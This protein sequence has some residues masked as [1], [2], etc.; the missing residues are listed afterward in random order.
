[1][2]QLVA[3]EPFAGLLKKIGCE[4]E[5]RTVSEKNGTVGGTIKNV[6]IHAMLSVRA[7]AKAAVFFLKVFPMLPSRPVD[8]LTKRPEVEKVRYPTRLGQAEGEVYRPST[9]DPHPGIVVCL[10]V[11]PFGVDHPQVPI[12]GKA[13]ARAGFAALLYWSPAMR[14]FRLDA[15]DV[16]NIALAYD[17]FIQQPYVDAAR[18]GLLGTCVGG[19]FALMT[20]ARPLVRDRVAFVGAYAPY[21]SMW[22]FARDIASATRS[23]AEGCEPWQVDPLTRKVFVHSLAAWLEPGES[24]RFLDAFVSE[25]GHLDD[26]GLSAEG[27]AVHALLTA[28]DAD[29]AERA[30]HGLPAPMQERIAALSPV[31]C[32]QDLYTPL[33]V[34][35]H[36]RGDQV[37]PV[38]ESRRLHAALAGHAGVRYTEMQFS[39]L[40]PVKGKLPFLRL[41]REL[42]KFFRAV[43]PMFRQAVARDSSTF[44]NGYKPRWAATANT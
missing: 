41:V 2:A 29:E 28:P 20:A 18:S 22:T 39:H 34:L 24:E 14:D 26:S 8:W 5:V 40:D 6:I 7:A 17:W 12:L 27:W 13:L 38:G 16:D 25:R 32:L 42:A 1:M 10:G 9:G 15:E 44:E 21:S 3:S 33:I 35:L 37:I 4:E 23:G 30:L 36:D 11:V 43:Y 19:S 31:N